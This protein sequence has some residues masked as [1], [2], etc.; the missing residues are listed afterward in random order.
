MSGGGHPPLFDHCHAASTGLAGARPVQSVNEVEDPGGLEEGGRFAP[1]T[2]EVGCGG[3]V[4]VCLY[5]CGLP[6]AL[7]NGRTGWCCC[8]CAPVGPLNAHFWL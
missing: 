3:D 8:G 2:Q 5:V 7:E 4:I 1:P 6:M